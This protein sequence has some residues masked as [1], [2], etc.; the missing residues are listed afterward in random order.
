MAEDCVAVA[1][2]A[3]GSPTAVGAVALV[4]LQAASISAADPAA[5][6]RPI[7]H[8]TVRMRPLLFG[9]TPLGAVRV[10]T[11]RPIA[12]I[13]VRPTAPRRDVLVQTV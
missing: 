1:V 13:P 4:L 6:V 12:E 5:S 3:A 2:V 11:P 8:K 7:T 10:T 9:R